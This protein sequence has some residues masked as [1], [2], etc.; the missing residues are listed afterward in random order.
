MDVLPVLVVSG[1]PSANLGKL[2]IYLY[3]IVLLLS[4][5]PIEEYT[6]PPAFLKL[7][8]PVNSMTFCI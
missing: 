1:V 2:F 6:L 4:D 3:P 5:D 8:N 7:F